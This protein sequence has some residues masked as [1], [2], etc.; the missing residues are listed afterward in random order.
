[1][2]NPDEQRVFDSMVTNLRAGDPSFA[3]RVDRIGR[4]HHRLWTALAI[5][6][7]TIAPLLVIFGGWTGFL[8]AVLAVAY[9]SYLMRKRTRPADTLAWWQPAPKRQ[10]S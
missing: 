5:M 1:M 7:W 4:P 6:L 8:E 9:G 10:P 2:L 3:R